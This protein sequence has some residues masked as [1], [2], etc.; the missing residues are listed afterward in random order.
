MDDMELRVL[1]ALQPKR[2]F[3]WYTELPANPD[4]WWVKIRQ[5]TPG[6][7]QL[8]T[9]YCWLEMEGETDAEFRS[10]VSRYRRWT[11]VENE[12]KVHYAMDV[13]G[14]CFSSHLFNPDEEDGGETRILT[15]D[16]NGI[17]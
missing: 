1:R 10:H 7:R 17:R 13:D 3:R 2:V 4:G 12:F 11:M 5:I 14:I 15:I 6:K 9:R 8:P 16:R